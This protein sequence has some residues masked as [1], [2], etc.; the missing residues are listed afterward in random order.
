MIL[1]RRTSFDGIPVV[2][3]NRMAAHEDFSRTQAIKTSSHRSFGWVFSGFFTVIGL[4]PV[5]SG[6]TVRW[7][8]IIT[9]AAFLVVSLLA[10]TLFKARSGCPVLVNTSF[11]VRGEPIVR[12]PRGCVQMFYGE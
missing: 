5:F 9:A 12:S 2:R 3:R 8:S 11:D 6:G 10:P 1:V 4:W 7:W